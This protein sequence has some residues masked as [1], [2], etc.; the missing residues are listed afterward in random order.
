MCSSRHAFHS[1][2][3]IMASCTS[4]CSYTSVVKRCA[5]EAGSRFMTSLATS[6]GYNV[7]RWFRYDI[8][9]GTTVACCTARHNA[10]V[11]HRCASKAGSTLMTS[12][13]FHTG[14]EVRCRFAQCS[15][16]VVTSRAASRNASMVHRSR[17]PCSSAVA[18]IA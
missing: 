7:S 17:N 8:G 4:A 11:I 1:I 3:T 14:W 10:S 9:I 16:V 5:C 18:S 13:T 2:C 15:N 6:T 12:T